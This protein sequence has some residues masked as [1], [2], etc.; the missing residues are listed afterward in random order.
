MKDR[1]KLLQRH[2]FY[3]FL[4]QEGRIGNNRVFIIFAHLVKLVNT[5]DLKSVPSR[6]SVQ[7]R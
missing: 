6:L 3:S 4:E 2:S 5:T 1:T 7:V